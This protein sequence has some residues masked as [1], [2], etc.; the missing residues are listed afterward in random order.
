MKIYH[1]MALC[2]VLF[3]QLKL[4][5]FITIFFDK[6]KRIALIFRKNGTITLRLWK[7]SGVDVCCNLLFFPCPPVSAFQQGGAFR[8]SG[9]Q[10]LITVLL[11]CLYIVHCALCIIKPGLKPTCKIA[12]QGKYRRQRSSSQFVD[13]VLMQQQ[14][15][16]RIIAF[17][18]TDPQSPSEWDWDIDPNPF[19]L[20]VF[21][22]RFKH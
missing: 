9:S 21:V 15:P 2:F 19:S 16:R 4:R 20:P 6:L 1:S 18:F 22:S 17:S 11:T 5:E 3:C 10:R 7:Q 8:I 12:Q 14:R 13:Y